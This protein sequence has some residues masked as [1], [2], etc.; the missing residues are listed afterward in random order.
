M[1]SFFFRDTHC[2]KD[3]GETLSRTWHFCLTGDLQ[4]NIVVRKT[5][6]REDREL[7]ATDKRVGTVYGRD[8]GLDEIRRH[9]TGVWI[10]CST[11]NVEAFLRN[12]LRATVD[13]FTA[14]RQDP[15]EHVSAHRHLDGLSCETDTAVP[16][17]TCRGLKDLNYD[18]LIAGVK[19]LPALG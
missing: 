6:P 12:N 9:P 10:D 8:T 18:Q 14:T 3:Y 19:Y 11:G 2:S 16:A 1:V 15:A 4:C 13:R 17:D 5:G 7:L